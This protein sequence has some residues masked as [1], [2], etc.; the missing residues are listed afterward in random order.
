MAGSF[1]PVASDLMNPSGLI[2]KQQFWHFCSQD[3]ETST[4]LARGEPLKEGM[5][6]VDPLGW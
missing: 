2:S 1:E 4:P 3:P 6:M 5:Q